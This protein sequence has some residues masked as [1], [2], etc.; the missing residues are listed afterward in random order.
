MM[1]NI[2]YDAWNDVGHGVCLVVGRDRLD[3]GGRGTDQVPSHREQ[4]RSAMN[5]LVVIGLSTIALSS[6]SSAQYGDVALL[7]QPWSGQSR[8]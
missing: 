8:G 1:D 4:G 6:Q 7:H 2:Q 3:P 5:K